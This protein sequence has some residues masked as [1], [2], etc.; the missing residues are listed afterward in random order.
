MEPLMA[1][2]S[3]TFIPSA[4]KRPLIHT[5][6][7][8]KWSMLKPLIDAAWDKKKDSGEA[9]IKVQTEAIYE[10]W[11]AEPAQSKELIETLNAEENQRIQEAFKSKAFTI[12][13]E[14]WQYVK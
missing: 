1:L 6:I 9:R 11:E 8:A 14:L 12:H 10:A 2:L 13:R 5:Y 7:T 3:S 4:R